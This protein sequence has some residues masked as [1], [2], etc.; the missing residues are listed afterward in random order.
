LK[1]DKPIILKPQ[2]KT[3]AAVTADLDNGLGIVDKQ[4]IYSGVYIAS[5]LSQVNCNKA[6]ARILNPTEEAM[7]IRDFKVTP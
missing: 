6:I 4:E 7:A 3:I 5:S 2:T 1:N